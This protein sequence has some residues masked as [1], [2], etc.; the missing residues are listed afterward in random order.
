MFINNL[1]LKAH[2]RQI[3]KRIFFSFYNARQCNQC[4]FTL[5]EEG[6]WNTLKHVG[7]LWSTWC[8]CAVRV[9]IKNT[10]HY[11]WSYGLRQL[12][13]PVV[14]HGDIYSPFA[15]LGLLC[16]P[17]IYLGLSPLAWVKETLNWLFCKFKHCE[18]L[19][20]SILCTHI[21]NV[22]AA[23]LLRMKLLILQRT[24]ANESDT[25]KIY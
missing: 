18:L 2:G 15:A 23:G 12:L 9:N 11:T 14:A 6:V 21:W 13:A 10:L 20:S 3:S 8:V 25:A 5:V 19:L 22:V 17:R 4:V 16:S 24:F 1:I 7:C